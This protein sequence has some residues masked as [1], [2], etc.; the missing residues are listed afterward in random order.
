M[1]QLS[2][3][4]PQIVLM[5]FLSHLCGCVVAVRTNINAIN[6]KTQTLMD[7]LKYFRATHCHASV[8]YISGGLP[9]FASMQLYVGA[10]SQSGQQQ[11]SLQPPCQGEIDQT[12]VYKV[13]LTS[14]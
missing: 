3:F 5:V 7:T 8:F 6:F 14:L 11:Y 1:R 10:S 9:L 12:S 2:K 13:L 4:A